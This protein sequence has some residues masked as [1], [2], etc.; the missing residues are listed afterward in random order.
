MSKKR[1]ATK[2]KVRRR[3]NI[4]RAF[5]L[6]LIIVMLVIIFMEIFKVD[7]ENVNVTGNKFVSDSKV[8]K[9]ADLNNET[10]YLR[11]SSREI[12]KKVKAEP[13]I[14]TCHV[15]RH[16]GFKLT[17]EVTENKP[18]F[19][20]VNTNKL[21]L[22]DESQIETEKNF[23]VP[24]LINYVP[25]KVLS[26]FISGLKNINSDIIRGISEIEYSPSS[27]NDGA[28]IDEERFMLSMNDGNVVYINIRNIDAL[29]DYEKIYASIGDR[30][31]Y[32]NLDSDYNAY[33][34]EEFGAKVEE[35]KEQTADGN[36]ET[37]ETETEQ[38]EVEGE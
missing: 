33:Y 3:L 2:K 38:T 16:I 12:C 19:F 8:I 21:V 13:F 15:K 6:A 24:N 37:D 4:K 25:E 1:V 17:I 36:A 20:Y 9:L 5:L 23:G 10:S 11:I 27:N 31:G 30:K 34:F 18:L 29:N 32:Y 28:Y 35:T 7:V 26:K 22:S 14:N